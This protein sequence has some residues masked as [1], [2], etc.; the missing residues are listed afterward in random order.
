VKKFRN[1]IAWAEPDLKAAFFAFLWYPST[2][3]HTTYRKQS[4]PKPMVPIKS[5][6]S[7]GVPF[8]SS[9]SLW[10]GIWEIYVTTEKWSRDHH[11]N[12]RTQRTR[13][14][15]FQKCYSSWSKTKNNDVIAEKPFQNSDVS[16]L[17][18]LVNAWPS[19]I[20]VRRQY[21]LLV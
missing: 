5:R 19:W 16:H 14:H 4:Y 18:A 11:E 10:P 8:A 21:I 17:Q 7:E 9:E 13:I 12:W 6:G 1:F 20:D 2:I 3:L 15:W